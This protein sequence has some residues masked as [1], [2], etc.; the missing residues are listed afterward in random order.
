MKIQ[1]IKGDCVKEM[2]AIPS[3]SV[4]LILTDPPYGIMNGVSKEIWEDEGVWD[5]AIPPELIFKQAGR[6]LKPKG[7]LILFSK[8]P[9]T[10]RLITEASH[11]IKFTQKAIWIKDTWGNHL[12]AN[13]AL[14]SK[15]EDICIFTKHV[16]DHDTEHTHPLRAYFL[17]EKEK[18]I[19]VNFK[20]L[21]GNDMAGHY[22]TRGEQFSCPSFDNY[23]KLQTTGHFSLPYEEIKRIHEE[24]KATRARPEPSIF[25]LWDGKK[26]KADVFDYPKDKEKYHPTQKPVKLLE[27]LIQ[28]YTNEGAVVLDFTMGSGSTGVAC[29]N[30]NRDFIGIELD[31]EFYKI[32]EERIG[33]AKDGSDETD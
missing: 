19:D 7:K 28:I 5:N 30:T 22:F 17:Q 16:G 10:S 24:W 18:C 31:D 2:D 20:K 12:S 1:L 32:A 25:N 23:K 4:D 6:I 8:E 14:L 29:V 21:L 11:R 26:A 9:Y 3:N 33:G 15:A 27:D 13:I